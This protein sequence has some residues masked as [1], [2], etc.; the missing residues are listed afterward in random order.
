MTYYFQTR[1][2]QVTRHLTEVNLDGD[3]FDIYD[4]L[5]C[6]EGLEG[7]DVMNPVVIDDSKLAKVLEARKVAFRGTRGSYRRDEA[8]DEFY[9]AMNK[10]L[11]E[12]DD[13]RKRSYDEAMRKTETKGWRTT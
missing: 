8:W 3:W 6:L 2:R 9:K 12:H 7:A 5:I 10:L 1:E 11:R 4:V 13:E